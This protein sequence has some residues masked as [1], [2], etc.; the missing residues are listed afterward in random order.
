MSQYR[1]LGKD[2][3]PSICRQSTRYFLQVA[4]RSMS[5]R[6]IVLRLHLVGTRVADRERA[7]LIVDR[8]TTRRLVV[9]GTG[10]W[11]V[12]YEAADVSAAMRMCEADLEHLDQRWLEILDFMVVPS[13]FVPDRRLD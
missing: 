13:R 4:F 6:S 8:L 2:F 12:T 9:V 1:E 10:E 5:Q 11:R 3:E 7:E